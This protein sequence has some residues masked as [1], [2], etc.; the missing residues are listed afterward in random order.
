MLRILISRGPVMPPAP[1]CGDSGICRLKASARIEIW[2]M[3]LE[4]E[5]GALP[6][7]NT[8]IPGPLSCGNM[9]AVS[10]AEKSRPN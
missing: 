7:E 9:T 10:A 4:N 1:A 3:Y 6:L 5:Q 8:V 2:T